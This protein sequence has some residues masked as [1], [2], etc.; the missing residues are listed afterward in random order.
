MPPTKRTNGGDGGQAKRMKTGQGNGLAS[1]TESVLQ[2]KAITRFGK[3]RNGGD[4]QDMKL[5]YVDKS[6]PKK[7]L[8][9]NKTNLSF[10]LVLNQESV[11][12]WDL[13]SESLF[14]KVTPD[15]YNEI[16]ATRRQMVGSD[17]SA[18]YDGSTETTPTSPTDRGPI[19]SLGL[20]PF[21]DTKE[22]NAPRSFPGN[23]SPTTDG[24]SKMVSSIEDSEWSL[25]DN[26]NAAVSPQKVLEAYNGSCNSSQFDD[27]YAQENCQR[28]IIHSNP[29]T[30]LEDTTATAT[31][32]ARSIPE[33]ILP[34]TKTLETFTSGF[35]FPTVE[36]RQCTMA[37]QISDNLS[38]AGEGFPEEG[39]SECVTSSQTPAHEKE[40]F[41]TQALVS[42]HSPTS[43]GEKKNLKISTINPPVNATKLGAL[44]SDTVQ[45]IN[46]LP[47]AQGAN[48][49]TSNGSKFDKTSWAGFNI[50]PASVKETQDGDCQIIS[51]K[52]KIPSPPSSPIT[53]VAKYR[54]TQGRKLEALHSLFCI[55]YYR[56]PVISRGDMKLALSQVKHVISAAKFY[57]SLP[58]VKAPIGHSL[59]QR[60]RLL[61]QDICLEPIQWLGVSME[62][63]NEII[64]QEAVVHLVGKF[65]DVDDFAREMFFGVS[66]N[67]KDLVYRKV[68]EMDRKVSRLNELLMASS[69]YESG[70]RAQLNGSNKNSFDVSILVHYWREWFIRRLT[71]ARTPSVRPEEPNVQSK[72]G[73]LYREIAAGGDT[74]L[75]KDE[76][77]DSLC[78]LQLH[79]ADQTEGSANDLALLKGYASRAVQEICSNRSQLNPADGGFQYLTCTQVGAHEFPWASV[80]RN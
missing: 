45:T 15:N 37:E 46:C 19:P 27:N 14:H 42:Q 73:I 24:V 29:K 11:T 32:K 26:T 66:E 65:S 20:T 77:M 52:S 55:F 23:I 57:K 7:I 75:P 33:E 1:K 31:E 49:G 72:L 4:R 8:G 44:E 53:P 10:C 63:E 6:I 39:A 25:A 67:V 28:G 18:S 64:F 3:N 74:Y 50:K 21:A 35:E 80:P 58:A 5:I 17:L 78:P 36:A 2:D 16:L 51:F 48:S 41:C 71:D 40:M 61:Y 38:T 68:V 9:T 30:V 56:T 43:K 76:V 34:S 12:G 13:Q 70:I 54:Q 47:G 69:I 59:A 22:E 60:G 79:G 62:L